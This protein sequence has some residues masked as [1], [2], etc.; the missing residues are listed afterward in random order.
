MRSRVRSSASCELRGAASATAIATGARRRRPRTSRSPLDDRELQRRAAGLALQRGRRDRHD[1]LRALRP[2]RAARRQPGRAYG[3]RTSATGRP[4]TRSTSSSPRSR[5]ARKLIALSHVLWIDRPRVPSR[6]LRERAGVP[7]LVDGAQSAGAVPVDVDGRC[8]FYTVSGQKWLL[9]AGPHR[10]ALRPGAPTSS[11]SRS[12]SYLSQR[13][14]DARRATFEPRR[15]PP[16]STRTVTPLATT[17]GLLEA[18]RDP[19]PSGVSSVRPRSPLAPA[20]D[21]SSG[22][23]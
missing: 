7:V 17:A 8:D 6:E 5:R 4:T 2:A 14:Y 19:I 1:R 20:S 16:A 11:A 9:R 23:T 10:R 15:A 22:W 12:P 13:E 3:S 21:S 18:F